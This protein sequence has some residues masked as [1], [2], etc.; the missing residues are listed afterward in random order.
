MSKNASGLEE[1]AVSMSLHCVLGF[2]L[3]L[4]YESD[5]F[6]IK[7]IELIDT[8]Y[9]KTGLKELNIQVC[10]SNILYY[11]CDS[12]VQYMT[13]NLFSQP[14]KEKLFTPWLIGFQ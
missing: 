5:G 8:E 3:P 1:F 2:H 12:I 10:M 4:T 13:K 14:I 6:S 7:S 9:F 11:S